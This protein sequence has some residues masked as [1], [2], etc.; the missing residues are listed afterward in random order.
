MQ[1]F[2][3]MYTCH[4]SRGCHWNHPADEHL[5]MGAVPAPSPMLVK[6][7]VLARHGVGIKQHQEPIQGQR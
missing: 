6:V 3:R 2:M 1:A 7:H 5:S 4:D